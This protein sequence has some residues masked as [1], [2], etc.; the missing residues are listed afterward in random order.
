MEQ[1]VPGLIDNIFLLQYLQHDDTVACCA[2]SRV[3]YRTKY[4]Y[5]LKV[6]FFFK[7]P[8]YPGPG[9]IGPRRPRHDVLT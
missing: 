6:V 2:V 8:A 7:Q 3:R 4:L 9:G 5:D 1:E